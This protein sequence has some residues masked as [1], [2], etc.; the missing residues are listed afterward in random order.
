MKN[1]DYLSNLKFNDLLLLYY[2]YVYTVLL[3]M[4]LL[5][6]LTKPKTD[7]KHNYI[8]MEKRNCAL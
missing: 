4:L 8:L 7:L 1:G 3:I 6:T 5:I 2:L